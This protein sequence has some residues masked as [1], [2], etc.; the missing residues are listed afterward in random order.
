MDHS[1]L[2]LFIDRQDGGGASIADG[3][4]L[5]RTWPRPEV[6]DCC[7]QQ[8]SPGVE[9]LRAGVINH[10]HRTRQGQPDLVFACRQGEGVAVGLE[11]NIGQRRAAQGGPWRGDMDVDCRCTRCGMQ[12]LH[13]N[14]AS[15]GRLV[16]PLNHQGTK[17]GITAASQFADGQ[18]VVLS[19][20]F[21]LERHR[22]YDCRRR[23]PWQD[24]VDRDFVTAS[25]NR[26]EPAAAAIVNGRQE[27]RTIDPYINLGGIRGQMADPDGGIGRAA[28]IIT[29]PTGCQG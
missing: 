16:R 14:I 20:G 9:C 26:L 1:Q 17:G 28:V 13:T 4:Q 15:R 21:Q 22:A 29:P 10:I 18:H 6:I 24:A 25:R 27:S 7:D 3:E 8:V 5:H 2:S 12:H 11:R 23:P 19:V